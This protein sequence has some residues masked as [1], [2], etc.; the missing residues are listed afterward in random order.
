M[1]VGLTIW[2]LLTFQRRLNVQFTNKTRKQLGIIIPTLFQKRY[3]YFLTSS[4]VGVGSCLNT[5]QSSSASSLAAVL[6]CLL[7]GVVPPI[8]SGRHPCRNSTVVTLRYGILSSDKSL[9]YTLCYHRYSIT[10]RLFADAASIRLL[11]RVATRFGPSRSV[12]PVV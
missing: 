1:T 11:S 8:R 10:S 2:F 6:V 5:T 3:H 12:W 4:C 9:S 7:A